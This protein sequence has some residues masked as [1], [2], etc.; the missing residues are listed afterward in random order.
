[1]EFTE[2]APGQGETPP[3]VAGGTRHQNVLFTVPPD[4][5]AIIAILGP[6]LSRAEP[7]GTAPQLLILTPDVDTALA[8]AAALEPL[9]RERALTLAAVS[10]PQRAARL[11]RAHASAILI[12]APDD[13]GA[14]LAASAVKLDTLRALVIA[15]ADAMVAAEEEAALE[16]VMSEVP[17]DI[18]RIL[19][20]GRVTP[21]VEAI[22]E[23]YLRRATR[24]GETGPADDGRAIDAR[25]VATSA[26]GRPA[27]LR[28]VLDELD[29]PSAA[30]VVRSDESAA[31][32]RAVL[33][34]LGYLD[35]DPLVRIA[36]AGAPPP[37][38]ALVLFY[39]PPLVRAELRDAAAGDPPPANLVILA[40]PRQMEHLRGL[41]MGGRLFPMTFAGPARRAR[42]RDAAMR[43]EIRARLAAGVHAR[44]LLTLEPLLDDA[45][46][47][48]IG[49]ALLAMLE[50]ARTR[51]REP[52]TPAPV[53]AGA[54]PAAA[55][56]PS[57]AAAVRIFLSIGERDGAKRGDIV[58]A[59]TGE[60]AVA[61]DRIGRIEMRDNHTLV[62]IS[63]EVVERVLTAVNGKMIRG[64]R[65][66]ARL[67]RPVERGDARPRRERPARGG[68][69]G[70]PAGRRGGGPR[71][72]PPRRRGD[73]R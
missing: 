17:K 7:G 32:V 35:D 40:Q 61:A 20:T 15:G 3:A 25:V 31:A 55:P 13:I 69:S 24:A 51:R 2:H 21:A 56:A 39:D 41:A 71:S 42:A 72:S 52:A 37:A 16:T 26:A 66:M 54:A 49:A 48:E 6:W 67:D 65:I 19:L 46:G 45:D 53:Q 58:G 30:I 73:D 34:P 5:H 14:I 47:I 27:A 4:P 23:R 57:A 62:D 8:L 59:I 22:V 70:P 11:Q 63:S 43:D 12:G 9:A 29:P 68:S 60:A 50:E 64:R 1:M 10:E 44:E 18:A 28:R 36:P 38:A 33:S